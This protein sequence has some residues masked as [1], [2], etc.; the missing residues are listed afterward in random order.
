MAEKITVQNPIGYL[1][2]FNALWKKRLRQ[3]RS[4]TFVSEEYEPIPLKEMS[5]DEFC[6]EAFGKDIEE[7]RAEVEKS[8][9]NFGYRCA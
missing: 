9:F 2:Y 1:L 4:T 3:L 5:Y 8:N 7:L 6:I